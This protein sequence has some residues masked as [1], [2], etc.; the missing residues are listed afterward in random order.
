MKRSSLTATPYRLRNESNT[1]TQTSET[2]YQRLL[3]ALKE[4]WHEGDRNEK[5]I[6]IC[7]HAIRAGYAEPMDL[8]ADLMDYDTEELGT[9]D[10]QE[11]HAV[12]RAWNKA[13]DSQEEE[14]MNGPRVRKPKAV[15]PKP[16]QTPVLEGDIGDTFQLF[17]ADQNTDLMLKALFKPGEWIYCGQRV[18][19]Q[20]MLLPME[21]FT[22]EGNMATYSLAAPFLTI[23]P[24]KE[25]TTTG[26]RKD[27]NIGDYRHYLLEIDIDAEPKTAE[28][29]LKDP[30]DP[31]YNQLLIYKKMM[32]AG[33][34]IVTVT[35]S[36]N[37]SMHAIIRVADIETKEDWDKQVVEGLHRACVM[38][39]GADRAN[40][41]PSRLSRLAGHSRKHEDGTRTP[42]AL[43]YAN[44][45]AQGMAPEDIVERLLTILPEE[46]VEAVETEDEVVYHIYELN[47]KGK[48]VFD[49][50]ALR[51]LVLSLGYRNILNET[52]EKEKR[53]K[54][55]SY[56]LVRIDDNRIYPASIQE[57]RSVLSS[58]V[59]KHQP[60]VTGRAQREFGRV[61]N[62]G[63]SDG[64]PAI[65]A[66][67]HQDTRDA[68]YLYFDN[69]VLK[70]SKDGTE[71]IPYRDI[72]GY[73]WNSNIIQRPFTPGP[74]KGDFSQFICNI[75][76]REAKRVRSILGSLGG[77]INRYKSRSNP[78][79]VIYTDEE[80][81]EEAGGTGKGVLLQAVSQVRKVQNL[82]FKTRGDDRFVWQG[83]ER[84]TNVVHVEDVDRSFDFTTLFN[85]LTEGWEIEN[86]GEPRFTIPYEI[87]PKIA[88]STN[89]LFRGLN[90][91]HKRRKCEIELSA[92]YSDKHQPIDD[93]SK[94]FF[95]DEWEDSDWNSFYNVLAAGIQ[96]FHQEGL[97]EWVGG[98]YAEK[99]LISEIGENLRDFFDEYFYDKITDDKN[100]APN[101]YNLALLNAFKSQNRSARIENATFQRHLRLW[102][103]VRDYEIVETRIK[104]NNTLSE[105]FT[106][107]PR[108]VKIVK[109]S[110]EIES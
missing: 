47:D 70:I 33:I 54:K 89:Y 105:T 66:V 109:K 101:V 21:N 22:N 91:S 6:V 3:P 26:E 93:F 82:D 62:E 24:F 102:A 108:G 30:Q 79:A 48:W 100:T 73:I 25:G 17:P 29:I 13:V 34:P 23:N 43:L 46:A 67:M 55:A 4:H 87:S 5:L 2:P 19:Q 44:P 1:P 97:T 7:H 69:V 52:T 80:Y 96:I 63:W 20:G 41:N 86:K 95:G 83:I 12:E 32:D 107:T 106:Q 27:E 16:A 28:E 9:G 18:S 88:I 64:L 72:S 57:L 92:H 81:E 40:G 94:E 53:E 74:V 75:A 10:H 103:K 56:T 68:T 110:E 60:G 14:K 8:H 99:Q 50:E 77:L 42:Q 76:G 36:G 49:I 71:E 39:L 98:D 84:D 38:G 78:K 104:D 90:S 61:V 31:R 45:E 59:D 51:G 85:T 35:Y 11:L 15:S 37:K 58:Y 65:E